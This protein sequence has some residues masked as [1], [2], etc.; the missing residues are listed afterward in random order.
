VTLAYGPCG[1]LV[2]GK[3][4][5]ALVGGRVS[6]IQALYL[7]TRRNRVQAFYLMTKKKKII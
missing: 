5:A 2:F 6:R 1:W 3:Y 4:D 7:M